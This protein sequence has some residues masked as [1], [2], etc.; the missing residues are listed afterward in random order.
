[1]T[2]LIATLLARVLTTLNMGDIAYNLFN[3]LM[4]LLTAENN[5][6]TYM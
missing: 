2:L 1:M 6:K 3:F 5:K 4:T